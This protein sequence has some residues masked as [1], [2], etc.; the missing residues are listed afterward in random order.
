MEVIGSFKGLYTL[1]FFTVVVISLL[2]LLER[3]KN[4]GLT[5]DVKALETE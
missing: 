1:F 2:V 3:K 4:I 5:F